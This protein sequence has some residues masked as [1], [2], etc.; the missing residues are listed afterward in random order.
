MN[1]LTLLALI[2][3][4]G[5]GDAWQE[6][7]QE[8]KL[9]PTLSF[10][11]EGA[12]ASA[13]LS[14]LGLE[15]SEK[16]MIM[17]VTPRRRVSRL[18]RGFVEEMGIRLPGRGIALGL[19]LTAVGGQTAL[20]L[21]LGER[22]SMDPNE[23]SDM[24]T[25]V[26]PYSLVLAIC[27]SGFSDAVMDAARSAGARGGTVVHAKGTAGELA[28]KFMGV[29]LASEKEMVLIVT[30][31]AQRTDIMRAVMDQAGIHSPAHAV[32]LSLPVSEVAGLR[33]VQ[34]GDEEPE[35]AGTESPE[36]PKA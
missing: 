14:S 27:E 19:P 30:A 11:C 16:R 7:L 29:S 10:P 28:K 33:S 18:F 4:D 5:D 35:P 13:L 9:G 23:V 20:S 24:N 17:T 6:H 12:A 1:K 31:E 15:A 36:P 21:L 22:Q 8:K 34:P 26:Y 2:V 32:V 3:P 25:T